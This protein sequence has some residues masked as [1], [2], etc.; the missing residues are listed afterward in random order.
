MKF[1]VKSVLCL[2]T[3]SS[4]FAVDV[5]ACTTF[6]LKRGGEVL[7]GKNYDWMIGDGLIFVNR[8]GVAKTAMSGGTNSAGWTSRYGSITFNQYGRENPSGGMN[9]AGLVVELM[10]LDE[11]SYPAADLRP[12]VDTL[13]WI[14]YQL[15]NFASVDEVVKANEYLRISSF[16][17]LHYLVSDRNG[18]SSSIE[19]LNGKLV[20]HAGDKMP[21]SA[22]ANDTYEKSW[23]YAKTIE[24]FGGARKLPQSSSSLDR[25][26]RAALKV[27]EF[28]KE[29]ATKN[30]VDYA[31]AV[32]DD[33]AQKGSTQW[34]IVYDQKAA[35]IYFRTMASRE[36][37]II[38]AKAFDYSCGSAVKILDVNTN[39]GGDVRL[40]FVDYTPK[41]NRD[42]IERSFNGTEFLRQVP[43][44]A[45]DEF[46]GHVEN[47]VCAGGT[48][49]KKP[50]R[51]T[52]AQVE[53]LFVIFPLYYV[54]VKA[55]SLFEGN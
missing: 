18:N 32:L 15:D 8:R 41:A 42:L 20:A 12:T 33:V 27:R 52:Q 47:F 24:S 10:W 1:F 46:A 35:I 13:E 28:E 9:E 51:E 3:L 2:L 50:S 29:P 55:Q 22:L 49:V 34:S 23:A 7:F 5:F 45:R 39:K 53:P 26:T 16:V 44:S 17:K 36:I 6:C 19:F 14:Q 25:F 38:D 43:A 37:K 48:A 11:T 31:F 30:P 4:L 21:V 54:F 40:S